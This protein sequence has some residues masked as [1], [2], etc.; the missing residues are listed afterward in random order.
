MENTGYVALSRQI[1]LGRK[2]DIV[3]NNIANMSTNGYQ[4][5][6]MIFSEE[7]SRND[8]ENGP[9]S[10]VLDYGT[11][12]NLQAGPI[13][14]T[15]N[16]LD[17]ALNGN[18]YLAVQGIDGQEKYTR[19]GSFQLNDL[20]ELVNSSGLRILDDGGSPIAVPEGENDIRISSAG[21]VATEAGEIAQ[22]KIV[23]FANPQDMKLIGGSLFE[24][25]QQALPDETTQVMQGMLEQSNVNPIIEMTAMIE[26]NRAYQTTARL[27]QN[28][29]DRQRDAIRKLSQV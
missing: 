17:I 25:E 2:M 28:E 14:T 23:G 12:R 27:L 16:K 20:R 8:K 19:N 18:G 13:T 5:Q 1:A 21:A 4:S 10:M 15:G 9:I 3:S 26:I 6:H 7:I 29:H 24:T 22:L 11:Y